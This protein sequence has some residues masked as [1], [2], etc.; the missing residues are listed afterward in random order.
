MTNK[1]QAIQIIEN[2]KHLLE[3]EGWC[4]WQFESPSGA[5]CVSRAIFEVSSLYH[6]PAD[7]ALS[8]EAVRKAIEHDDIIAWND[9][10][11]RTKEHVIAAFDKAIQLL[12]K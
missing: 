9:S 2:A 10:N 5:R 12:S 6:F 7:C 8:F 3:T 11:G 4:Q 1:E